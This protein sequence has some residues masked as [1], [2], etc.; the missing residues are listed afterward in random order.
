MSNRLLADKLRA[1]IDTSGLSAV[2]RRLRIDR[3]SLRHYL[4]G[5]G[6]LRLAARVEVRSEQLGWTCD[7]TSEE[8]R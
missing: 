7:E 4:D 3:R 6:Q 1:A 2:S 8:G 5:T